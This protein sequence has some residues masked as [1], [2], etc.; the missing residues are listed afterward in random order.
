MSNTLLLEKIDAKFTERNLLKHPF[1][2][3]RQAG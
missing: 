2:Q 1:Y 3:G